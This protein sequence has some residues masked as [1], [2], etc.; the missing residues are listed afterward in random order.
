[1]GLQ[2]CKV[3]NKGATGEELNL[4]DTNCIDLQ[5]NSQ[6]AQED[7]GKFRKAKTM[8]KKGMKAG[9]QKAGTNAVGFSPGTFVL[10]TQGILNNSYEFLSKLG[11]GKITQQRK[12][13]LTVWYTR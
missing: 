3:I 1:M 5:Y 8:A 7:F 6:I 10:E 12:Q 2:C 13:E 9:L 4:E 11:Q